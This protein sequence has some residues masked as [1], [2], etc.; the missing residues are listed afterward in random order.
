VEQEFEK[1]LK[2]KFIKDGRGGKKLDS[3]EKKVR[4]TNSLLELYVTA[5]ARMGDKCGALIG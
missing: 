5:G 3:K 1:L 4:A 2:E